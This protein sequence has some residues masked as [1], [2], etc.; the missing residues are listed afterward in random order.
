VEAVQPK[1]PEPADVS[2]NIKGWAA[3]EPG[4]ARFL[5]LGMPL[6]KAL[7]RWALELLKTNRI[8]QA[9]AVLRSALTLAPADPIL[10]T[11]YGIALD[12]GGF[13]DEAILALEY[14][15]AVSRNQPDTWL[16]LGMV[17]KKQR[18]AG[19]AETAYRTALEQDP[20][21][22]AAWQLLAVLKEEQRDFAGAAQC[23]NACIKAGGA[24]AA[25]LANLGK[26]NHQ[27]GR[28]AESSAAY[29]QASRLDPANT[30]YRQMARKTAFLRE[31]LEDASIDDAITR[32][33]NSFGGA[34]TCPEKD[35]MELLHS[36][37]S[38]L[39]GFGHVEA[40]ARVGKKQV[41]LWPDDHSM[42][43]L[44]QAVAGD[45][46]IDRAPAEYVV[47]H[48]DA[49]AQG[50]DAQL[51]DVLGYDIPQKISAA[52]REVTSPGHLYD[53][54]DAGCGTGLC[55]PLLR[56]ISRA[57]TGV[58]LSPKMLEQAGRKKAYDTLICEELTGFLRRSTR[59]FDLIVAA[60]L[61]IYFGNLTP[62]F[63]SAATALRRN[64]LFAF[65]TEL[66]DGD[67]YRLLPSGRFAHPPE[68]VRF[69]AGRRFEEVFHADTTIRMEANRRLPGNLF[70]FRWRD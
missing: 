46:T 59:Q 28:I 20:N 36:S 1:L 15:V 29:G 38:L 37:F 7:P 49:F 61:M 51:V 42:D 60:D 40:A 10:W 31:V 48:F 4:F 32:Y 53:A 39:S 19:A 55:G 6:V 17:K 33:Q 69:V 58:D 70:I 16:M 52:V 21:S 45:Q 13:P 9:I 14:S 44:L 24:H 34:E 47:A 63:V 3:T 2:E 25:V 27:L 54:L 65:S 12:H 35:L 67:G 26:L 5:D 56:P 8:P 41:Q 57:L 23:L 62:V 50:F 43:Y 68:Y 18:Q 66:W 30:H 64:G 22:S 11:N